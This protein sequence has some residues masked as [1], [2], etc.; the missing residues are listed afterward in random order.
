MAH[1][2]QN[3]RRYAVAANQSFNSNSSSSHS[4]YTAGDISDQPA[5]SKLIT[6]APSS[7]S[8]VVTDSLLA[9]LLLLLV[10]MLLQL[11]LLLLLELGL[12]VTPVLGPV[13]CVGIDGNSSPLPWSESLPLPCSLYTVPFRATCDLRTGFLGRHRRSA[14]DSGWLNLAS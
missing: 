12:V 3:K 5:S 13:L 8:V 6:D 9:P 11:L 4:M 2:A 10:L 7:P 1:T 14:S